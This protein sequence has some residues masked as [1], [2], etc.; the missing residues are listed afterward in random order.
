MNEKMKPTI[1]ALN[2]ALAELKAGSR[3]KAYKAIKED[4]YSLLEA[5]YFIRKFF[6][7]NKYHDDS[8]NAE[9]SVALEC[10]IKSREVHLQKVI[11]KLIDDFSWREVLKAIAQVD[12]T[13]KNQ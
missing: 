3:I 13:T 12:L 11:S 9:A 10:Y 6:P 7:C 2:L 8:L 1:E 4:G 5:T